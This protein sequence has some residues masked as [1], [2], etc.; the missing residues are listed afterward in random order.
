[1]ASMLYLDYYALFCNLFLLQMIK[2]IFINGNY[3][4]NNYLWEKDNFT[5]AKKNVLH[6]FIINKI[7]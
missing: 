4:G 6:I 7:V 2:E 1:M 3:Q 5:I